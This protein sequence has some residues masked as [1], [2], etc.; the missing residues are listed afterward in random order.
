MEPTEETEDS[1]AVRYWLIVLVASAL[2]VAWGLLIYFTVRDRPREWN[3]EA[4]PDAP[5][6]SIYSTVAPPAAA[7]P[8]A[9]VLPELPEGQ[10]WQKPAQP[11]TAVPASPTPTAAPQKTGPEAEPPAPAGS[12]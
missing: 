8:S 1:V 7:T 11:P 10:P 12:R 5:G 4:L 6:E 3:F 9:R 2:V